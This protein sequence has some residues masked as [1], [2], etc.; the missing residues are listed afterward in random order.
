[1]FGW[2]C[3]QLARQEGRQYRRP[4]RWHWTV[5]AFSFVLEVGSKNENLSCLD[6][7]RPIDQPQNFVVVLVCEPGKVSQRYVDPHRPRQLTYPHTIAGRTSLM[8]TLLLM[9][10]RRALFARTASE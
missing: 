9:T 8:R 10:V 6:T 4:A 7:G 3:V 5:S 2:G 1:M